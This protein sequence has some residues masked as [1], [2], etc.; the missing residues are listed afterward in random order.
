MPAA[1]SALLGTVLFIWCARAA[2]RAMRK[3]GF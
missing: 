2:A 3:A 1:S